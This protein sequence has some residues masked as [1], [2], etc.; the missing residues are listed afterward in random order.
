MEKIKYT[1]G[2]QDIDSSFI[3]LEMTWAGMDNPKNIDLIGFHSPK[4]FAELING[5][6]FNF[7]VPCKEFQPFSKRCAKLW[8]VP[9]YS[10]T[11]VQFVDL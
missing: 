8:Q 4:S 9:I 11:F 10:D 5:T 6:T 1:L 3:T 2:N 7:Y